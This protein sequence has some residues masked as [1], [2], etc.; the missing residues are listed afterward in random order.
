M[1]KIATVRR[2]NS[3]IMFLMALDIL[4]VLKDL[5]KVTYLNK[6]SQFYFNVL[7]SIITVMENKPGINN[8]PAIPAQMTAN[9]YVI[10]A[11]ENKINI[12]K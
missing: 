12:Y 4:S 5:T 9:N 1:E 10:F 2:T 7:I 11:A 8:F 3:E 6:P